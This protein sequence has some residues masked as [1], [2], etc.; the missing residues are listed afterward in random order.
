MTAEKRDGRVK[1]KKKTWPKKSTHTNAADDNN[2]IPE[3][4]HETEC[5]RLVVKKRYRQRKSLQEQV[6]GQKV[7]L[8]R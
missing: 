7:L 2:S 3:E 8:T 4:R 6:T 1:N 5:S